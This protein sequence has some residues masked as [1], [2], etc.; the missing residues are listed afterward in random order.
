MNGV[1]MEGPEKE[2]T[3][4]RNDNE[5]SEKIGNGAAGEVSSETSKQE[6]VVKPPEETTARYERMKLFDK[7][8]QKSL[9]KFI[10]HA[11]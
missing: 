5:T 10:E 2:E 6:K 1:K 3:T 4:E 8:M 7:A 9:N 11:R